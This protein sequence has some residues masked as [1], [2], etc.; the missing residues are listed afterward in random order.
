MKR[1]FIFLFLILTGSISVIKSQNP[2][3]DKLNAYKIAFFTKRLELTSAEAEK[4]WPVYNEYQ[5]RKRLI[6]QERN[7]LN[8][9]FNLNGSSMSEK[10]L[11]EA[12]D[13][14][15]NLDKQETDY[16]LDFHNRIK[17][18]LNPFKILRYYQ[19]ENQYKLQLLNQIQADRP[20]RNAPLR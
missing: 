13:K 20:A 11:T 17:E 5:S 1:L 16:A 2:D 10:E 6:Q 7:L 4:F 19:A 12:G 15:I 18:I 3:N 9:N 14:L 8:R